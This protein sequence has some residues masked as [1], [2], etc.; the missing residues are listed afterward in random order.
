MYED[1][2]ELM[3]SEPVKDYIPYSWISM[4][5]VKAQYYEAI[6]HDHMATAILDQNGIE[7]Y[8]IYVLILYCNYAV[9]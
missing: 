3:S 8:P 1:A 4:A 9:D 6:A 7:K 2:Q 5:G